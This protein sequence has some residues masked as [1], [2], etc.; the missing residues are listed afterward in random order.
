MQIIRLLLEPRLG[1]GLDCVSNSYFESEVP[2]TSWASLRGS[3]T[4][5]AQYRANMTSVS[6]LKYHRLDGETWNHPPRL[7]R[8]LDV[9]P[10]H[11]NKPHPTRL[12][13]C[14][15]QSNGRGR[16]GNLFCSASLIAIRK[17]IGCRYGYRRNRSPV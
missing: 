17:I 12:D 2:G 16:S 5:R 1:P 4:T 8:S 11:L 3:Y 15:H 6:V 10:L 13:L 14:F 9:V 7:E